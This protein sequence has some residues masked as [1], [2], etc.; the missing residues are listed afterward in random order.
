MVS[1]RLV[2]SGKSQRREYYC[3]NRSNLF[4][5]LPQGDFFQEQ[6]K[7]YN[8]FFQESLPSLLELYFPI[9]LKDY[10]NQ[11]KIQVLKY[12]DLDDK[13]FRIEEP[14]ISV[15]EAYQKKVTWNQRL[16]LKFLIK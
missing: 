7:S 11:V 16:F 8:H 12:E 14:K 2:Q 1:Y 5:S 3:L 15:Q 13:F 6:K 10:N 4:S 9:Q